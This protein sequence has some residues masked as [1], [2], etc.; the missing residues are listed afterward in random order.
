MNIEPIN[1]IRG[2]FQTLSDDEIQIMWREKT[3]SHPTITPDLGLR[4]RFDTVLDHQRNVCLVNDTEY[5]E[6]PKKYWKN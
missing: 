2:T 5:I 6:I 3:A 1:L 4:M